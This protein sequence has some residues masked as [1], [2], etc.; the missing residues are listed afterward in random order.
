M[1]STL[2]QDSSY[3][4]L[5]IL[6]W[7]FQLHVMFHLDGYSKT[8]C[9]S[10][11]H[12]C[13]VSAMVWIMYVTLC[14]YIHITFYVSVQVYIYNIIYIYMYIHRCSILPFPISLLHYPFS[15]FTTSGLKVLVIHSQTTPL[16]VSLAPWCGGGAMPIPTENGA[17]L[18]CWRSLWIW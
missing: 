4:N 3:L 14:N 8:S 6:G 2:N 9:W 1:H 10:I 7:W 11:S 16:A 13:V 5:C 17:K 18:P 15:E 12:N